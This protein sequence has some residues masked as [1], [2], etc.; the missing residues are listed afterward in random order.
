M[1]SIGQQHPTAERPKEQKLSPGY[2]VE[3]NLPL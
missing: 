1:T 3:T 2:R